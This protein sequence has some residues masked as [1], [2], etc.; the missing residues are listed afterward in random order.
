MFFGTHVHGKL[1]EEDSVYITILRH[2][3]D[4]LGSYYW[5]GRRNFVAEFGSQLT[6]YTWI[7]LREYFERWLPIHA[8]DAWMYTTQVAIGWAGEAIDE[9]KVRAGLAVLRRHHFVLL[10]ER[11][12]ASLTLLARA[13]GG[14]PLKT[15]M[16]KANANP[17]HRSENCIPPHTVPYM[18]ANIRW[19]RALY[20][21]AVEMF[22]EQLEE[23]GVVD[24]G[25]PTQFS[26]PV[27]GSRD[28]LGDLAWDGPPSV[29]I[30]EAIAG[31]EDGVVEGPTV[32]F[33]G[34]VYNVYP[35][36]RV[37]VSV[38]EPIRFTIVPHGG[39]FH[40]DK[41]SHWESFSL[42]VPNVDHNT[43]YSFYLMWPSDDIELVGSVELFGRWAHHSEGAPQHHPLAPAPVPPLPSPLR[44]TTHHKRSCAHTHRPHPHHRLASGVVPL[45][46]R[47]RLC[48]W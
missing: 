41:I 45:E 11:W 36:L 15:P 1:D 26:Y 21:E 19:E 20:E 33:S 13:M 47:G 40:V 17:A 12:N 28:H 29:E 18:E 30:D 44:T 23:Y 4:R 24:H 34:T 32:T 8:M 25:E 9:A 27:C 46:W 38:T 42:S 5:F 3:V 2:P 6:K 16:V 39:C 10:T 43:T 48:A 37:C 14:P 22:A 7:T 35:G 31:S